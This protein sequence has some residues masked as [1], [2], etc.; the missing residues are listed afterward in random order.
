MLG[1]SDITRTSRV[2]SLTARELP[3]AFEG[4]LV[5]CNP[6]G[7]LAPQK[8]VK[9]TEVNPDFVELPNVD[10]LDDIFNYMLEVYMEDYIALAIQRI[11]AQLHHV[12]NAVM[13]EIHDVFHPDKDDDKDEIYLKK[14]LKKRVRGQLLRICCDLNLVITQGSIPYVSLSIPVTIFYQH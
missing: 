14:I 8:F 13:T 11:R 6:V 2:R 9:L 7:S 3:L 1:L 4:Y 12:E 5:Y 10:I